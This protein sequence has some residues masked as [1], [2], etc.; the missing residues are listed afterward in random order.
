MIGTVIKQIVF[1]NIFCLIVGGKLVLVQGS[2]DADDQSRNTIDS[3][4]HL[5]ILWKEMVNDGLIT[6]V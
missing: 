3:V 1:H 4:T 6:Q 2:P 5:D